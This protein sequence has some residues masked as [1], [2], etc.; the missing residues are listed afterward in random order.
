M[1]KKKQT[2]TRK[3]V[4]E[5]LHY[6]SWRLRGFDDKETC[7]QYIEDWIKELK[8]EKLEEIKKE[9]LEKKMLKRLK[10]RKGIGRY[11]A[12]DILGGN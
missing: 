12:E 7:E 2:F 11:I 9:K 1:K 6:I 3:E 10:L 8:R 4:I 5:L